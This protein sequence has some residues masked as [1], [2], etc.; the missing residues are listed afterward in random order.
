[1]LLVSLVIRRLIIM[2]FVGYNIQH[3]TMVTNHFLGTLP[4]QVGP[5][6]LLRIPS[7]KDLYDLRILRGGLWSP[8]WC[9]C[10][11]WHMANMPSHATEAFGPNQRTQTLLNVP[12]RPICSRKRAGCV[13]KGKW[14]AT[15]M[16]PTFSLFVDAT[17][18]AVW[19]N[20]F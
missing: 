12:F 11:P 4:L 6:S 19:L 9:L 1:M 15:C 18:S 3:T 13:R 8:P 20:C 2:A 7:K 5:K 10:R 16:A 17:L 14:E